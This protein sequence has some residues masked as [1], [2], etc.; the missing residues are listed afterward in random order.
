MKQRIQWID[1]I[2]GLLIILMVIGHSGSFLTP[3][4]Y[5]FHMGTFI[6]ISGY[7]SKIK[8]YS[9]KNYIKHKTKTILIP[10]ITINILFI[11]LCSVLD[12]TNMY[13]YFYENNFALGY[14]INVF[15]KYLGTI[16]L[17]GATWFLVVIYTIQI[18]YKIIH[19]ILRKINKEEYIPI[20]II[21]I[22]CIGV[23]LI[24]SKI[25]LPYLLDLSFLGIIFFWLGQVF[26]QYNVLEEKIDYKLC[27]PIGL[28]L[29][30]IFGGP[31]YIKVNWPTREFDSIFLVI[32]CPILFI[33]IVYKLFTRYHLNKNICLYLSN[34]GQKT[35]C[36]LV[37]HFLMFRIIF[38]LGYF[39]GV[40]N[41][42]CL[43]N[44]TPYNSKFIWSIITIITVGGC[45]IIGKLAEKNKYFNY[46]INSKLKEGK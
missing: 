40:W 31:L 3:Y 5:L 33:S 35:Y 45:Y 21:L 8:E 43:K 27:I 44:L 32:L 46:I 36:I 34:I 10:Y 19:S 12:L 23:F 38:V 30:M 29:I 18:L 11:L 16:D 20:I 41:I 4:I 39:L 28:I 24:K 26:K 14:S 6:F 22:F 2:K 42:S 1:S 15:F 7:T 13:N 37:L 17:G 9:V 25:Y